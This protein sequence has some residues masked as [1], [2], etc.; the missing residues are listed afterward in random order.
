MTGLLNRVRENPKQV[1]TKNRSQKEVM[2]P[3]RRKDPL[4]IS[5]NITSP[6]YPIDTDSLSTRK[7]LLTMNSKEPSTLRST[8]GII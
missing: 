3:L 7:I 5:I 4:S 1:N 2:Q 8:N 6:R